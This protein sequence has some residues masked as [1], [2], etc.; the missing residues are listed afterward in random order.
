LEDEMKVRLLACDIDNTLVRFPDPPS[1]PVQGA[2]RA[3][4]DAGVI[5]VLSTG[6]AFR[7]AR[8]IAELL[9]L[10][11][12]IICNHGG[13]IRHAGTGRVL[14]RKVLPPD[15]AREMVAWL[16][17]QNVHM[18][19]FDGDLVYH[20]GQ[21]DQVVPDFQVYTRGEQSIWAPDMLAAL[22]GQIE[23]ILSTSPDHDHLARVHA[24]TIARLDGRARV[25]FS[26]P[27]GMDIMPP[28][29]KSEALA[30][31]SGQLGIPQAEVMAVGDGGNDA[32]MLAWAGLGIAMGDGEPE[33][34]AAADVVAPPF[35]AD[36]LAWA[37][38]YGLAAS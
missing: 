34:L 36:G 13:S 27:F 26:H 23:I 3:A 17:T 9:G 14:Y 5:V 20:D 15:L 24:R 16:Q 12:P 2:I 21:T 25:L 22:P 29:S 37:I 11:T 35:T 8:P 6:R 30:W 7:R 38:E 18:F 32:D 31:L 4:V 1:A 19:C 28:S 10:D 33:A